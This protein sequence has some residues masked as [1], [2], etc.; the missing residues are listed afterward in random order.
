M[1]TECLT[2]LMTQDKYLVMAWKFG[3]ETVSMLQPSRARRPMNIG[4]W[5]VAG[6]CIY[7]TDHGAGIPHV[8]T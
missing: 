3:L 4:T 6:E 8:E 5:R 7:R 2:A 1:D